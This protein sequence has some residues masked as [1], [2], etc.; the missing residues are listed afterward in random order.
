MPDTDTTSRPTVEQFASAVADHLR[1]LDTIDAAHSFTHLLDLADLDYSVLCADVCAEYG[2]HCDN[3][4]ASLAVFN[5]AVDLLDDEWLEY[6]HPDDIPCEYCCGAGCKSCGDTGRGAT[7]PLSHVD[8]IVAEWEAFYADPA[9]CYKASTLDAVTNL[10]NWLEKSDRV[11]TVDHTRIDAAA[12]AAY[13]MGTL[14]CTE[15]T[16]AATVAATI[17]RGEVTP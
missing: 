6:F 15:A 12:D 5:A 17:T 11:V 3:D 8:D 9:R 2:F 16:I 13:V 7:R 1:S 4:E 14:G 10:V